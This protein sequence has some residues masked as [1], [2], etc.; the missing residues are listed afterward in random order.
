[1][2][3]FSGLWVIE[4]ISVSQSQSYSFTDFMNQ[5]IGISGGFG[6]AFVTL[7]IFSTHVPEKEFRKQLA[8]FFGA[9]EK[10][11]K[12]LEEHKPW[13]SHGKS[14]LISTNKE[15]I[16]HIQMCGLWSTMLNYYRV[17]SNDKNKVDS[18]LEA[19]EALA[20]RLESYEHARRDF[21]DESLLVSLKDEAQELREAFTETFSL[22]KNSLSDGEQV[23]ELP[24]IS[25]L[26]NNIHAG[27]EELGE[28]AKADENVRELAGQVMVVIG[29]YPALNESI[30]ECRRRV[31]ALDWKAWD[32]AYF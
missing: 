5:F 27:L 24:D 7:A 12:E 15:L 13:T 25:D 23:P 8:L 11:I 1:M 19:I 20:F 14:I 32:Q 3:K 16:G 2:S 28:E 22:F 29:F 31:N 6:L 26:K 4:L 21:K 30:V 18:L 9:C 17:A 10:T